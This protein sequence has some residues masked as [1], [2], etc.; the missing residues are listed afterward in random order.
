MKKYVVNKDLILGSI[1]K[2]GFTVKDFCLNKLGCSRVNFYAALNRIYV[3][4]RSQFMTKVINETGLPEN[5]IWE[6]ME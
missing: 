3:K 4:P 1:F 6:E 5:L 2:Q